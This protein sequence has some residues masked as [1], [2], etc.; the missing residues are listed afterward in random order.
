MAAFI[1]TGYVYSQNCGA[2]PSKSTCGTVK[3]EKKTEIKVYISKTE[4]EKLFHFKDCL[5]KDAV[6]LPIVEVKKKGYKPCPVC[7]QKK[8]EKK[9]K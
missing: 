1:F 9:K 3:K 6:L 8:V 4:T 5:K 7:T 2:C